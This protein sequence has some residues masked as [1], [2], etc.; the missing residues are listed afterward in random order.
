MFKSV[1]ND[2]QQP[3]HI[4]DRLN[5]QVLLFSFSLWFIFSTS[6][7]IWTEIIK[8]VYFSGIYSDTHLLAM[9]YAGEMCYWYSQLKKNHPLLPSSDL[10][11]RQIGVK[12]LQDYLKAVKGPLSV[13]GWS[14]ERAEQFLHY[15]KK[16]NPN[17]ITTKRMCQGLF[18]VFIWKTL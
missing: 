9:M 6:L 11:E 5:L 13:Q 14:T 18:V 16:E 4:Y 2:L 17:W 12:Y 8:Y 1:F 7:D 15:F 10:D 3:L